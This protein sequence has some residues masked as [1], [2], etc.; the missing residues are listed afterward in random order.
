MKSYAAFNIVVAAPWTLHTLS[1]LL[2]SVHVISDASWWQKTVTKNEFGLVSNPKIVKWNIKHD[3]ILVLHANSLL[4]IIVYTQYFFVVLQVCGKMVS[5]YRRCYK[6]L[7][8]EYSVLPLGPKV[9]NT[10]EHLRESSTHPEI[11]AT[12]SRFQTGKIQ[13]LWLLK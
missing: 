3:F 12:Y 8:L 13:H 7:W 4:R 2:T 9:N 6:N 11:G 10:N 1:S 5:E